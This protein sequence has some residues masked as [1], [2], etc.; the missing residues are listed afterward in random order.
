MDAL[1]NERE[2]WMKPTLE[3]DALHEKRIV[4]EQG[5][6]KWP[7]TLLVR[8]ADPNGLEAGKCSVAAWQ[9]WFEGENVW[10]DP[11]STIPTSQG[12]TWQRYL[13]PEALELISENPDEPQ[14]GEL[15]LVIPPDSKCTT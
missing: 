3:I 15:R 13:S 5:E 14:F 11:G 2:V 9:P 4:M 8:G 6:S 7:A 10:A 12:R 1:L